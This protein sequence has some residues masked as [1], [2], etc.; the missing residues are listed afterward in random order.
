VRDE[1]HKTYR[2]SH[3]WASRVYGDRHGG[4]VPGD[5]EAFL[6][7]AIIKLERP[8]GRTLRPIKGRGSVLD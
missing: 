5:L 6:T 7:G 4:G 1:R 2:R 3:D 8:A